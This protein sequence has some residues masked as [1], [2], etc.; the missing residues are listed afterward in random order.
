MIAFDTN[1]LV[2]GLVGDDPVQSKKAERAFIQHAKGDGVFVSLVVL[3]EVAW[4]LSAAYRWDRTTIH[5]RLSRLLRTRGVV[6]ENLSLVEAALEGYRVGKPEL[7]DYLIVGV[8]RSA[9]ASLL[10]FD[11]LLSKEAGV[12]LL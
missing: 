4:V 2:R 6:V 3:A 7:A 12:T 9:G 1:V 11:K 5:D 10:T 8:A